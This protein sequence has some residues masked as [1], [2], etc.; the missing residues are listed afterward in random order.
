VLLTL[1]LRQRYRLVFDFVFV[2][3]LG[4]APLSGSSL[5]ATLRPKFELGSR[6][7]P[8]T[9]LFKVQVSL[10]GQVRRNKF[11]SSSL[12]RKKEKVG[13]VTSEPSSEMII[14]TNE[15]QW[16]GSEGLLLKATIFSGA[17]EVISGKMG[18]HELMEFV[19]GSVGIFRERA[20][21]TLFDCDASG[22]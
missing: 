3:L 8:A 22:S 7:T 21:K 12:L 20:A 19:S 6:K 2:I 15:S 5:V 16:E 9:M 17:R 18:F 4:K 13:T 1:S 10:G 14:I 11:F